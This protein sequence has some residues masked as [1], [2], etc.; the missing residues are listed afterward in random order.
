MNEHSLTTKHNIS[1]IF[2]NNK[3]TLA[4]LDI[5]K[6]VLILVIRLKREVILYDKGNRNRPG[7]H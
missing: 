1:V 2:V 7:H 5:K 6:T 3:N 4:F